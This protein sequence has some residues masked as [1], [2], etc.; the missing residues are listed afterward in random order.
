MSKL[1]IGDLVK[2]YEG[3]IALVFYDEGGEVC[4]LYLTS[5]ASPEMYAFMSTAAKFEKFHASEGYTYE[6]VGNVKKA[7]KKLAD[8]LP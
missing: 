8:E 1:K 3:D 7:F 6:V 2:D 4:I 5:D